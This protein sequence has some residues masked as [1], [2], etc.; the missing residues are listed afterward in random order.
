MHTILVCDRQDQI[1]VFRDRV[2]RHN[3]MPHVPFIWSPLL[4]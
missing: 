1:A 4:H 2:E 3:E